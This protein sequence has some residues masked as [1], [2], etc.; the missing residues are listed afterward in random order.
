[1]TELRRLSVDDGQDVYDMLQA[2]PMEENGFG[3]NA[4]GK[5][6]EEY[7]AWLDSKHRESIMEGITDGWKVPSTT[8]WLYAD[9]IP[10]GFGKLRHCLSD[11]LRTAGG[12]IGYAIAPQYRGKGYGKEL[13]RLLVREAYEMGIDKVLVT[14][15]LDNLVSQAV[16][17]ANGGVITDKTDER[18]LIWID[19]GTDRFHETDG[20]R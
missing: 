14:V 10:V 8:Y 5:T 4:H 3:N 18:V 1:M 19:T 11:A 2:I 6:Y 15:R 7:K 9:G 20:G 17:L 16:A 12:H 13:L